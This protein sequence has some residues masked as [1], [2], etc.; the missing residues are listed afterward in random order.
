MDEHQPL[1]GKDPVFSSFKKRVFAE[2]DV[3]VEL[4]I[5]MAQLANVMITLSHELVV[6]T[7]F[8][9]H[10]PY[11]RLVAVIETSR[12]ASKLGKELLTEVL[13]RRA[14]LVNRDKKSYCASIKKM[15][16]PLQS[17]PIQSNP[18]QSNPI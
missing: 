5:Y 9:D 14:T 17:N 12:G 18:I 7:K 3:K 2:L 4:C 15:V 1:D 13:R 8:H 10:L 11:S 16:R 6:A